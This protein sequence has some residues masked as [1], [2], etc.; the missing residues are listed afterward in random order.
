MYADIIYIIR[1]IVNFF[2]ILYFFHLLKSLQF[3][4]NDFN[5]DFVNFII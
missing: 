3:F 4:Q 2:F 5:D 1:Y